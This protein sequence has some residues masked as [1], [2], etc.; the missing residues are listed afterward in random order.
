MVPLIVVT[1]TLGLLAGGL[2]LAQG[3]GD[4]YSGCIN[5]NGNLVNVAV[6]AEPDA[7][8]NKNATRITWNETGPRGPKG[9]RGE[10]GPRGRRGAPGFTSVYEVVSQRIEIHDEVSQTSTIACAHAADVMTG[11][12][13]EILDDGSTT[14][15]LAVAPQSVAQHRFDVTVQHYGSGSSAYRLHGRC[16]DTTP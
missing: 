7:P 14:E 16:L 3:Q 8:C 5:P 11:A 12:G 9:A 10:P 2:A 6:G 4:T 1:L 13:Y 15:V